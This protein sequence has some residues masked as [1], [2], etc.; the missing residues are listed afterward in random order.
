MPII[1]SLDGTK[2]HPFVCGTWGGS[3]THPRH[4]LGEN[5]RTK[6]RECHAT[7]FPRNGFQYILSGDLLFDLFGGLYTPLVH[8]RLHGDD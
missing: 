2:H 4:L 7:S 6:G 5:N 3:S 1:H 8:P